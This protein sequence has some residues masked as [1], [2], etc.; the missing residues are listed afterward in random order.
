M[1]RRRAPESLPAG[2]TYGRTEAR[3]S[4]AGFVISVMRPV[5]PPEDVPLHTHPE[6]SFTF[7][8]SGVQISGANNAPCGPGALIYNPP[9]TTHRD[10][11][12]TLE[13]AKFLQISIPDEITVSSDLPK[14][15]T[16]LDRHET[17]G[18]ARA[19]TRE[20]LVW[21][22]RSPQ[23]AE[24]LCLELL[25][26]TGTATDAR[27]KGSVPPWLTHAQELLTESCTEP[28]SISQVAKTVGVHP[29]HLARNFSRFFK[30]TPGEHVRRSRVAKAADLLL[31]TRLP[32]VEIALACGFVDQSHF[33][34]IFKRR[35]GVS[36]AAFR[37]RS[38]RS[39][40]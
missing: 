5:L 2:E 10:R 3:A 28:V 9:G 6:G 29:A 27:R 24:G 8:L 40:D 31:E 25:A 23:L 37:A 21:D 19:L 14:T 15:P 39:P 32:L 34:H 12:Q 1:T 4:T 35:K 17:L 38:N 16:R 7:V 36:P 13:K 20:C 26:D 18:F 22:D 11:F 30:R 33:T